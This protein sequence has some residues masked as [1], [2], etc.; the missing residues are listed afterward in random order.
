MMQTRRKGIL[1]IVGKE[2]PCRFRLFSRAI[3]ERKA[4]TESSKPERVLATIW[5]SDAC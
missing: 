4:N 2:L 5:A 3:I 1:A